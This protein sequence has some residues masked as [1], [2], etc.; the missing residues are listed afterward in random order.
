M[1]NI[2]TRVPKIGPHRGSPELTKPGDAWTP[3]GKL[4]LDVRDGKVVGQRNSDCF[5]PT[6]TAPFAEIDSH[7]RDA[8]S[9]WQAMLKTKGPSDLYVQ[10][11]AWPPARAPAGIPI[12]APA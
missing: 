6:A 9:K 3:S 11:N 7:V 5:E 12:P 4:F 2:V 1:P 8:K 10:S